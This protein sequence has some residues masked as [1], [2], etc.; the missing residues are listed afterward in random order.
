MVLLTS[1]KGGGKSSAA[2]M[3]A[4][5]WCKLLG[6]KFSPERN[7][8]YTNADVS[9]K[10]E[11]LQKFE[12]IICDESV[13]FASADEW[14]KR[15]NRILRK[16]LAMVRPKHLLFIMCF[17]FKIYKLEK[18]YL[19]SMT[20]YWIDLY[21]RGEGAVFVKDKNPVHDTWRLKDF[22]KLAAYNEF[23]PKSTIEKEL[24][25]H[26][27]FWQRVIFPK[28]S[29]LVYN[30]YLNVRESNVYDDKNV[31]D[32]VN[33]EDI[34]AALLILALRDIMLHDPTLN[35]NRIILHI[36]NTYSIALQKSAIESLVEDSKQLV[37]KIQDKTID[38]GSQ[39]AEE[40]GDDK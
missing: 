6:L 29:E 22:L 10:L 2:L 13:K 25:K 8:A 17:P 20:T 7:I 21:S 9:N 24:K 11:N 18:T 30:R 31:L 35:F 16:K 38:F 33:K 19:E 34:H 36:K 32:N 26:P 37:A 4:I 28:P 3:I 23:T 15:D 12:V 14:A 1:D 39:I 5:H 40:K 27:N